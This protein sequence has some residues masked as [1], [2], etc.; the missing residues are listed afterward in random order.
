MRTPVR[1]EQG[2]ADGTV[3]KAFTDQLVDEY[4][5]TA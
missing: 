1:V 2:T 5:R 3:F 4:R